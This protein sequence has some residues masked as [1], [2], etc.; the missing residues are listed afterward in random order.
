MDNDDDDD[1]DNDD[2]DDDYQEQVLKNFRH[3]PTSL[4]G[5]GMSTLRTSTFF[6]VVVDKRK[7]LLSFKKEKHKN[8]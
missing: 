2:D 1:D 4:F 8:N 3:C 7:V 5:Q 6:L